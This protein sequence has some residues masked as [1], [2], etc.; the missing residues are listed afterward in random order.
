[1]EAQTDIIGRTNDHKAIQSQKIK[2]VK[3]MLKN[4]VSGRDINRQLK[5]DF[6]EGIGTTKLQRLREELETEEEG[7][8]EQDN[9]SQDPS[10]LNRMREIINLQKAK[11]DETKRVITQLSNLFMGMQQALSE[12]S[13]SPDEFNKLIDKHLIDQEL[14]D[15]TVKEALGIKE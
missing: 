2:W 14:I 11:A 10:L 6:G 15:F 7:T 13:L 3:N 1:M 5:I 4:G 12:N 8:E 9:V